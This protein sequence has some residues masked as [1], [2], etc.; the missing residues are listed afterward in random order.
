MSGTAEPRSES[1]VARTN[2]IPTR[3][4]IWAGSLSGPLQPSAPEDLAADHPVWQETVEALSP[5]RRVEAADGAAWFESTNTQAPGPIVLCRRSSS[6]QDA[7]R[8]LLARGLL[9]MGGAVVA[10]NQSAG[11]GRMGRAWASVS[12]NLHGT[13][14]CPAIEPG[15]G[16]GLASLAA[17]LAVAR[18]LEDL[19]LSPAIKWPNDILVTG[20]K[21]AGILIETS[22]AFTLIGIGVNTCRC[23]GDAALRLEGSFPA[24]TLTEHGL[25][26]GPLAL[27]LAILR[28]GQDVLAQRPDPD[29][30]ADLCRQIENR[31]A[32]AG[33]TVTIHQ[34]GRQGGT[35]ECR[36]LGLNTDGSLRVRRNGQV[37]SI[38]SGSLA[39]VYR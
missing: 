22:G 38:Y 29:Y 7:T 37:I 34:P 19:G 28:R 16:A 21:A 23:P 8:W 1:P 31:L 17:G 11:R 39:P 5:W 32:W 2:A 20:R 25:R 15:A 24:T 6:T 27:W 35:Y 33:Q 36:I 26:H 14:I 18:T 3:V 10:A 4:A 30:A 13:W 9:G 12:G